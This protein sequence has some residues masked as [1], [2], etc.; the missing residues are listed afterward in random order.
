[1]SAALSRVQ[2]TLGP[3]RQSVILLDSSQ[4]RGFG[5]REDGEFVGD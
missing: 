1:M 4:E 5:A 3:N 2:A